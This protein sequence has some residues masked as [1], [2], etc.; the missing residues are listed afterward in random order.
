MGT[1]TIDL[2]SGGAVTP[3]IRVDDHKTLSAVLGAS[4]IGGAVVEVRQSIN[5]T[6][7]EVFVPSVD[8]KSGSLSIFNKG[9]YGSLFIQFRVNTSDGGADN[10]AVITFALL[11]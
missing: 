4:P 6:I 7:W 1:R 2:T 8:M 5:D 11:G 10:A 9:V 3:S